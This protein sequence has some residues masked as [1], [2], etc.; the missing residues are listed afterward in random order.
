MFTLLFE[1]GI[2][3]YFFIQTIV[4]FAHQSNVNTVSSL[5]DIFITQECGMLLPR[6]VI[7][8]VIKQ[9]CI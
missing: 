3:Y 8:N 6:K 9:Y 2:H 1:S 4:V 7:D 5:E